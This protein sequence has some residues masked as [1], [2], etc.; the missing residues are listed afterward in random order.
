MK[1]ILFL[2][3]IFIYT[4]LKAE[5]KTIA[6]Y[7]LVDSYP[8]IS[9]MGESMGV[10]ID[11]VLGL[12]LN[13]AGIA[14]IKNFEFEV[15]H[16]ILPADIKNE[17]ITFAKNLSI[18]NIAL[19][20]S[21]MDFGRIQKVI[22]DENNMPFFSGEEISM[23]AY[24]FSFALSQKF[25]DLS[26]G[27]KPKIIYE[28]LDETPSIYKA[29]D[30][31]II[32]K[33]VLFK[34]FSYGL[35]LINVSEN[36]DGYYLPVNF[37]AGFTYSFYN[38]KK[39]LLILGSGINYLIA[40]N[41]YKISF[42][43]EYDMFDSISLKSG[44]VFDRDFK[45]N[46]V[47]GFGIKISNF[48][49]NYSYENLNDTGSVNKISINIYQPEISEAQEIKEKEGDTTFENLIKSSDYYYSQKQYSKAIKYLEYM[50]LIYWKEIEEMDVKFKSNFYQKLG[51]CYY[52][53]G[54]KTRAKQYFE[55]A[56]FYDKNNEVLKYWADL[57]K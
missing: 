46:F 54:D 57:M 2:V 15:M 19:D 7:L 25:N 41:F 36:I 39:V 34:N 31:G 20:M 37:N 29:L 24:I 30:F 8:E 16:S 47:A 12:S 13:P 51:I 40:E 49:L 56:L 17:K 33:N 55:R 14:G 1:K 43:F 52:N 22:A 42:G 18:F 21:F 10:A 32:Q 11:G 45:I 3:F 28:K 5:N 26:I 48:S 38:N 44:L 4:F 50:N 9:A 6:S 35:S 53:T 23:N 27:I